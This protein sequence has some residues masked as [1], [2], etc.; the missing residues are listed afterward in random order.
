VWA[1]VSEVLKR[2]VISR[3]ENYERNNTETHIQPHTL[4]LPGSH[5]RSLW[6]LTSTMVAHRSATGV[7]RASQPQSARWDQTTA[8]VADTAAD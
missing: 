7:T 8:V 4:R 6:L 2:I 1:C 3:L 5:R